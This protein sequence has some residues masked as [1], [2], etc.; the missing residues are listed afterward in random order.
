LWRI[1][2]ELA[3]RKRDEMPP[4]VEKRKRKLSI[5]S[6][7]GS[8]LPREINDTKVN[9]QENSILFKLPAELR[10]MIYAELFA[11]ERIWISTEARKLTCYRGS[12]IEQLKPGSGHTPL[13]PGMDSIP[14]LQSCRKIYTE[15]I[16]SLYSGPAFAFPNPKAFF[17]F[18]GSLLPQR[19]ASIKTVEMHFNEATLPLLLHN[20]V[21]MNADSLLS[22]LSYYFMH[23]TRIK[24]T[25]IRNF[26][27]P[28]AT[29]EDAE[30]YWWIIC[31]VLGKMEGLRHIKVQVCKTYAGWAARS[32]STLWKTEFLNAL[33]WAPGVS[34]VLVEFRKDEH[35]EDSGNG[36]VPDHR[37][38][39]R[40]KRT[41]V[42][43]EIVWNISA[44]ERS[45]P[46]I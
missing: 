7:T 29:E 9:K 24:Y 6:Q 33:I 5:S 43:D 4:K 8:I 46:E 11:E 25:P 21:K 35:R 40:W 28:P 34:D 32:S 10:L 37:I 38:L 20:E 2:K 23:R 13:T 3:Q 41:V 22:P 12:T 19:L 1:G 14:L 26:C 15:A 31:E 45:R 18:A 17:Y 44:D 27:L 42:D 36:G 16:D 39:E 30:P